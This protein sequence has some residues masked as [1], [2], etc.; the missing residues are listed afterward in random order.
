MRCKLCLEQKKLVKA[1]II[2]K[3]FYKP[4]RKGT[5]APR[6]TSDSR[7]FNPRKVPTGVYDQ[8]IVCQECEGRF[9]AWDD[10]AAKLLLSPSTKIEDFF[11][12]VGRKLAYRIDNVAYG[13]LKLF[14]MSVLWRVSVSSHLFFSQVRLGTHEA[15]LRAM[16]L[17][18]DPGD[19]N[20]FS[21]V[22]CRFDQSLAQHFLLYPH[23]QRHDG[24]N[25]IRLYLSDYIA[26]IKVDKR[27]P[28]GFMVPLLLTPDKPLWVIIRELKSSNEYEVMRKIAKVQSQ[29]DRRA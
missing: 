21:V 16:I 24:I 3:S 18:K 28:P 2:P 11:D 25:I 17:N 6:I 10:Y 19:E 8:T 15:T 22:L 29:R 26:E 7:R 13:K 4:M 5:T 12:E 1:H 23:R 9:Q 27:M 20:A 14:F